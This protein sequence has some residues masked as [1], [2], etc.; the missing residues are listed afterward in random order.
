[1]QEHSGQEKAKI[2]YHDRDNSKCITLKLEDHNYDMAV[3]QVEDK[4]YVSEQI[5]NKAKCS[6]KTGDST[7]NRGC[8]V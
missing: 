2:F 5:R 7:M 8:E 3:I 4:E 6:Y 1:M